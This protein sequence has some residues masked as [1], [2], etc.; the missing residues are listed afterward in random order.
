MYS[1]NKGITLL[2]LMI[3]VAII[4]IIAGVAYPSYR[5]QVVKSNRT[6]AKTA[7]MRAAQ[8][9]ER[10]Y[11]HVRT[12]VGCAGVTTGATQSNLYSIANAAGSPTANA[13]TLT[14]TPQ[15]SQASDADCARF[16]MTQATRSATRSDNSDN[17]AACWR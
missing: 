8:E 11:T 4:A 15:G 7:L 6:E 9:Y 2:E 17:T 10:C 3:T 14:A 5:S 13:F 1:K 16:T 12:Y